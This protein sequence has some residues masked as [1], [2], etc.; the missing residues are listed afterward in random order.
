M[1]KTKEKKALSTIT[2]WRLYMGNDD[3]FSIP[4]LNR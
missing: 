2:K 3:N 4:Y 1:T